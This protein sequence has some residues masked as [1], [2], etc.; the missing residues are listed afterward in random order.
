MLNDRVKELLEYLNVL[1]QVQGSGHY[2]NEEIKEVVKEIRLELGL[3]KRKQDTLRNSRKLVFE[4]KLGGNTTFEQDAVF[5][6]VFGRNDKEIEIVVFVENDMFL[7]MA[8]TVLK[9]MK[10]PV[11]FDF[12]NDFEK[13]IVVLK[14]TR[15]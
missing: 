6:A 3:E 11:K 13:G 14:V 1:S 2:V 5:E 8:V 10:A 7:D 9:E 4:A 15:K 12:E